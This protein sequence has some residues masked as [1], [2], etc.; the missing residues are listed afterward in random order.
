MGRKG[1]K[2][3]G[4]KSGATRRAKRDAKLLLQQRQREQE[5]Q[6]KEE[7]SYRIQKER[8]DKNSMRRRKRE[9]V[10]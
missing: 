9:R 6:Q 1:G 3:G 10:D 8:L 2:I 5:Q 7:A 4:V